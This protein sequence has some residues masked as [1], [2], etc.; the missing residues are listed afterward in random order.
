MR[1]SV[2]S[3]ALQNG[4]AAVRGV[5][6]A[7]GIAAAGAP[8]PTAAA[9]SN[10]TSRRFMACGPQAKRRAHEAMEPP[11]SGSTAPVWPPRRQTWA[12]SRTRCFVSGAQR[13]CADLVCRQSWLPRPFRAWTPAAALR[14]CPQQFAPSSVSGSSHPHPHPPVGRENNPPHCH[15]PWGCPLKRLCAPQLLYQN[16]FLPPAPLVTP[17]PPSCQAGPPHWGGVGASPSDSP[18]QPKSPQPKFQ[19]NLKKNFL[20][21]GV[22]YAFWGGDCTG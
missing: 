13:F 5:A 8:A 1:A 21:P 15:M 2:G 12:T 20:P 22:S 11:T 7:R 19:S 16:K 14:L 9:N 6:H 17:H 10:H 3:D 18:P 4:N